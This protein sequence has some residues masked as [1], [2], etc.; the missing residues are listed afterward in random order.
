MA[1]EGTGGGKEEGEPGGEGS[2]K[3]SER[4][5]GDNGKWY[6]YRL[7]VVPTIAIAKIRHYSQC[8]ISK[9]AAS[10]GETGKN[11]KTLIGC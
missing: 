6:L 10:R 9:V 5:K 3:C 2:G 11:Y 1:G 7:R 8:S 4:E